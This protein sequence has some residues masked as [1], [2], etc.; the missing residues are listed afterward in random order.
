VFSFES[1][2]YAKNAGNPALVRPRVLGNKALTFHET[3]E[4]RLFPIEFEPPLRDTD[5]F[6]ITIP[7]PYEV[8]ELPPSVDTDYSLASYDCKAEVSENLIRYTR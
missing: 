5:N 1:P 4:R 2:H 6:E 3:K 7:S 8:D